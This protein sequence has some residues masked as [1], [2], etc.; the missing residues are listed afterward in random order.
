[1]MLAFGL[2][3]A[4]L[5]ARAGGCGGR[6]RRRHA[7][8]CGSAGRTDVGM[9]LAGSMERPAR[10][11][12]FLDGGAPFYRCYEAAC[13]GFVSVGALEDKFYRRFLEVMDLADDPLFEA[14]YDR[15]LWDRQASRIGERIRSHTRDEWV[16][17]FAGVDACV[18]PVLTL[19]EAPVWPANRARGVFAEVDGLWQPAA[20]PRFFELPG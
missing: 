3:A 7:G 1:M 2:L 11:T 10:C 20:A 16:R 9:A 12:N 19:E 13:G 5:R 15:T 17:R 18:E 6:G 4:V 14:Q 8:R